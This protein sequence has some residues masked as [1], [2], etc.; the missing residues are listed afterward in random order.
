MDTYT[1]LQEERV[2]VGSIS[3]NGTAKYERFDRNFR[4]MNYDLFLNYNK[5]F[6]ENFSLK[7]LIGGNIRHAQTSSIRSATQ[8]GLVVPGLYSL[9][10]TFSAISTPTEIYTQI[11]QEGIFA[12]ASFGYKNELFL[13]ITA[14][15]DVSSSLPVANNT[16]Y[17]PSISGSYI[18]S[19]ILSQSLPALSF[20]KLR[21]NYAEVGNTAPPQSLLNT[22]TKEIHLVDK[23][24]FRTVKR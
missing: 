11:Y 14:R 9:S 8:G 15:R 18:F 4:E 10:N 24:Y 5:N 13:D 7:G 12:S 23:L 2:A 20:G 22:Y 21:L 6:S 17:Y 3:N 1:E 16:Y 19:N